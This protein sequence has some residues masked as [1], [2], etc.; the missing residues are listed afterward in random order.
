MKNEKNSINKDS[1][2][3]EG[4]VLSGEKALEPNS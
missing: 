4:I 2:A 3:R 1:E